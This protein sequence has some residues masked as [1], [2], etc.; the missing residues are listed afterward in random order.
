[1]ERKAF[2]DVVNSLRYECDELKQNLNNEYRT[3]EQMKNQINF[4][5]KTIN[6]LEAAKN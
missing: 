3:K 6:E 2:D 4:L 1:M 5:V